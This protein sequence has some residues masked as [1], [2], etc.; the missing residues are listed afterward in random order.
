MRHDKFDH[1]TRRT[2]ARTGESY[3]Q[4]VRGINRNVIAGKASD[5]QRPTIA[6]RWHVRYANALGQRNHISGRG[7]EGPRL[8]LLSRRGCISRLCLPPMGTLQQ[9]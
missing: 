1:V 4:V 6:K 2:L 7:R 5:C 9:G 3:Q 8:P